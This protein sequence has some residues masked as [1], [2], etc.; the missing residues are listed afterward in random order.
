VDTI[1]VGANNTAQLL[2]ADGQVAVPGC[3][4]VAAGSSARRTGA[5]QCIS[6]APQPNQ[7]P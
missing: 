5:A 3:A 1:L 4:A 7:C 2:G 6:S